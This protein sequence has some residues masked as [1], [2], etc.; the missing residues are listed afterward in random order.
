MIDWKLGTV[1]D[2]VRKSKDEAWADGQNEVK[3]QGLQGMVS[4]STSTAAS[5]NMCFMCSMAV[6]VKVKG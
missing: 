2:K 5:R 1:R 6:L 3:N 4:L